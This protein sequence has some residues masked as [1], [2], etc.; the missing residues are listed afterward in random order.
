LEASTSGVL[1]AFL[2]DALIGS[3]S[4]RLVVVDDEDDGP[5]NAGEVSA[6]GQLAVG[7][8]GTRSPPQPELRD[9]LLCQFPRCECD[10]SLL[11]LSAGVGH[12]LLK[13]A[14][15][16][17]WELEAASGSFPASLL[18]AFPDCQFS[19]LR[20][21]G[22]TFL[23]PAC[24]RRVSR[25]GGMAIVDSDASAFLAAAN[26]SRCCFPDLGPLGAEAFRF[27]I[28]VEGFVGGW[29]EEGREYEVVCR[30]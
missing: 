20:S 1:A 24:C 3:C 29:M 7:S 8:L 25:S 18:A 4:N 22:V 15:S 13:T 11:M 12:W 17:V 9:D 30:F 27:G 23:Q 10:F 16:G 28:V 2:L 14:A 26:D 6:M 21:C 19:C 5:E